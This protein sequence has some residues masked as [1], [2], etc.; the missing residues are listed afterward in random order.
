MEVD[1]AR[2]RDETVRVDDLDTRADRS[3]RPDLADDAILDEQVRPRSAQD[4]GS[5]DEQ[6]GHRRA[7]SC[8]VDTVPAGVAG[9]S[10]LPAS[11]W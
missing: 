2:E 7:P 3:E 11:R 1:E 6:A 4:A 9:A 5:S 10:S 8:A